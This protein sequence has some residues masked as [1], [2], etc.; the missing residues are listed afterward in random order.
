MVLYYK[1]EQNM[2]NL[3]FSQK[4]FFLYKKENTCLKEGNVYMKDL[5]EY[6]KLKRKEKNLTLV[7]LAKITNLT[8]GYISNIE[9]NTRK[10]SIETLNSIAQALNANK[11]ELYWLAGYYTDIEYFETQTQDKN[12]NTPSLNEYVEEKFKKEEYEQF[13]RLYYPDIK[14]LLED[15]SKTYFDGRLLDNQSKKLAYKLLNALFDELEENFP[16]S[17]ELESEF[18]RNKN[19]SETIAKTVIKKEE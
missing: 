6:I 12:E 1:S 4:L 16:Y 18:K 2:S 10:P 19:F 17:D 8:Q 7:Q 13:R 5:G 3:I 11:N 14:E 15:K 9:R